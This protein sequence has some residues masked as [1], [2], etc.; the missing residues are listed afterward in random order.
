MPQDV[1]RTPRVDFF[2][3]IELTMD[4]RQASI[5]PM[6]IAPAALPKRIARALSAV[7]SLMWK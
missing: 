7:D 4:C 6:E 3:R 5:V 2:A 1:I